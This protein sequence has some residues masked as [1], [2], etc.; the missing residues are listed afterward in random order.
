MKHDIAVLLFTQTHALS[1]TNAYLWRDMGEVILI[2]DKCGQLLKVSNIS[3][4]LLKNKTPYHITS[5][6]Q[7][8]VEI[9]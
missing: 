8:G 5:D 4:Q 6:Y 1:H 9:K 2:N 3:W 7:V